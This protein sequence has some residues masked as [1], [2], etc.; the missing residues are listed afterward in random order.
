MALLNHDVKVKV[1]DQV[2]REELGFGAEP[3]EKEEVT[4]SKTVRTNN[5]VANQLNSL[6]KIGLGKTVNE[7]IQSLIDSKLDS[8]PDSTKAKYDMLLDI[9]EKQDFLT[10][11]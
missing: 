10:H 5:H 11:K 9:A 8:L 6:T 1:T 4:Y 3:T 7:V 2:S